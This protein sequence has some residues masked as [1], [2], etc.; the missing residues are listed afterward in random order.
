MLY[1]GQTLVKLQYLTQGIGGV[2]SRFEMP[3][4]KCYHG[5]VLTCGDY[6]KPTLEKILL[7]DWPLIA[8]FVAFIQILAPKHAQIAKIKALLL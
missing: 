2:R 4:K 5:R 1:E 7:G 6:H 8:V 3:M